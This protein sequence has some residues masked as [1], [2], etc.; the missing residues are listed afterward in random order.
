MRLFACSPQ[1]AWLHRRRGLP[2]P[3]PTTAMWRWRSRRLLKHQHLRQHPLD[4][5][6]LRA[7]LQDVPQ[8]PRPDEDVFLPERL[9]RVRQEQGRPGG[10]DPKGRHQ[11]RLH[12]LQ[13]LPGPHRRAGEDDRPDPG[14]EAGLHP[15]RGNGRRQG[16]R[17]ISQDARRSLRPLA[18][19]DQVRPAAAEGGKGRRARPTRRPTP[20][21][22]RRPS[23]GSHSATTAS[24]SG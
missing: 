9:R 15:R 2:T 20:A 22:A 12:R 10:P 24:P 11:L 17:P 18:E 23:S 21:T 4:A 19:A 5:A 16:R 7:L 14:H 8:G 13:P 6:D 3:A 1:L